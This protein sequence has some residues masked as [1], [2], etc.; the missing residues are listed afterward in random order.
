MMD[1][2]R[3]KGAVLRAC[4]R[5]HIDDSA[6]VHPVVLEVSANV[7]GGRQKVEYF[8]LGRRQYLGG[9]VATQFAAACHAAG[10]F[11]KQLTLFHREI[12]S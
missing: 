5:F 2:L 3:A 4:A 9:F 12:L 11:I 10:V 8:F 7:V 1:R 6:E